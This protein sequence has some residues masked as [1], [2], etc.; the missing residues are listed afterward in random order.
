MAPPT[1]QIRPPRAWCEGVRNS[2]RW[3]RHLLCHNLREEGLLLATRRR[4]ERSRRTTVVI[5]ERPAIH[6][7]GR[8]LGC[9]RPMLLGEILRAGRQRVSPSRDGNIVGPTPF[10][11]RHDTSAESRRMG[12]MA[13]AKLCHIIYTTEIMVVLL[14]LLY[15]ATRLRYFLLSSMWGRRCGWTSPP[16]SSRCA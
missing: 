16:F 1:T 9:S 3:R 5:E 13:R 8:G 7:D 6:L 4:F 15:D 2:D 10:Y 14:F 11:I 12:T